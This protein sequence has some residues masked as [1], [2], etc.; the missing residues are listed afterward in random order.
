MLSGMSALRP[1][2]AVRSALRRA[3][4]QAISLTTDHARAQG[5]SCARR[6]GIT[7]QRAQRFAL[8]AVQGGGK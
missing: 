2:T 1:F 5:A 6:L 4:A 7:V 8:V 3:L